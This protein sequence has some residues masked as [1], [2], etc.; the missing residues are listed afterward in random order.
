SFVAL[1]TAGSLDE[2]RERVAAFGALDSVS[3]VESVLSLIPEDQETKA[4]ILAEIAPIVEPVKV[5]PREDVD[6]SRLLVAVRALRQR[7]DLAA[8]E[9]PS[10]RE[11]DDVVGLQAKTAALE[12]KLA[13]AAPVAARSLVALQD[14][15]RAD[16]A[17]TLGRLAR[18]LHPTPIGLADVP[19]ELRR[20][21]VG[22]S[23][24]FLL[25]IQPRVD[26]W[27]RAGAERFIRDLRTV[28]ADVA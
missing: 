16:F 3:E 25:Q 8:D 14:E 15:L 24:R 5:G 7:L 1:S 20:R 21:F 28:D 4:A 27:D 22:K 26:I 6:L 17:R 18:N 23:G 12:R 2:L 10:G 11:R 13:Q 19:G 9:A